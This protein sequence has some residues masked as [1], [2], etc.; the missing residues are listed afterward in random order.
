MRIAALVVMGVLSIV[1]ESVASADDRAA[2]PAYPNLGFEA[3][4][5]SWACYRSYVDYPVPGCDDM[6]IASDVVFSGSHS[7]RANHCWWDTAFANTARAPL[8]DKRYIEVSWY[9]R[10]VADAFLSESSRG[11]AD[12]A[13]FD[14]SGNYM[15]WSWAFSNGEIMVKGWIYHRV[16]M[17]VPQGA[18]S[19]EFVVFPG[20]TGDYYVDEVGVQETDDPSGCIQPADGSPC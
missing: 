4:F 14:Q 6:A 12:V 15:Q 17:P 5:G 3:G 8:V 16:K 10:P 7:L 13:F 11:S 20:I 2:V 19:A 9:E 1:S 18:K